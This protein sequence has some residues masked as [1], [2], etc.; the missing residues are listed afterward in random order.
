MK[1]ILFIDV[2]KEERLMPRRAP[3][4]E[5]PQGLFKR[6]KQRMLAPKLAKAIE[7]G[8]AAE[9][10]RLLGKGVYVDTRFEYNQ[11]ALMMA[12]HKG[13]ED[14]VDV[15]LEFGA[16]VNAVDDIGGTAL[17]S[18]I[19][20]GYADIVLTLVAHGAKITGDTE[21]SNTIALAKQIGQPR[22]GR[23]LKEAA[24]AQVTG[25]VEG[26]KAATQRQ[27]GTN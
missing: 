26:Y 16:D 7:K 15:L 2:S 5:P 17:I 3:L 13:H 27:A 21:T 24:K 20:G 9:V 23:F 22:I 19:E 10:G 12:C 14:V 8:D 1:R 25:L 4:A 6:L 18:A 11:T